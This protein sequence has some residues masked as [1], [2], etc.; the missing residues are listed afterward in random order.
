MTNSLIFS[1]LTFSI[2]EHGL[3]LTT[4]R[5]KIIIEIIRNNGGKYLQLRKS[6]IFVM[7]F[8]LIGYLIMY[9]LQKH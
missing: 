7:K 6:N 4:K 1:S 5:A 2:F 8:L 3:D 9:F